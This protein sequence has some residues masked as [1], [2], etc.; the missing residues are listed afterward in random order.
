M[1]ATNERVDGETITTSDELFAGYEIVTG[2]LTGNLLLD[3]RDW[4]ND[5]DSVDVGA[6]EAA[7]ESMVEVALLEAFPG[8][9]IKIRTQD[10]SGSTP[11]PFHTVVYPPDDAMPSDELAERVDRIVEGVFESF[12]WIV[13]AE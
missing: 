9:E 2:W 3:F 7:Y 12:R 10:G 11:I 8:A 5:D 13:W 1:T 6:T 4:W